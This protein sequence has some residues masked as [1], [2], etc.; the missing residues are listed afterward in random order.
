M[1]I[2]AAFAFALLPLAAGA[3]PPDHAG[4]GHAAPPGEI[5]VGE[6]PAN[7]PM[8]R[9]SQRPGCVPIER[10]VMG[11]NRRYRG[12][13][14]DRGPPGRVILAVDRQVNGCH[15]V[16]LLSAEPRGR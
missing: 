11:E 16:A 13:R 6:A 3:A 14:L 9:F 2:M 4:T 1:R 10:Q 15:E 5:R 12:T 8:N 7:D